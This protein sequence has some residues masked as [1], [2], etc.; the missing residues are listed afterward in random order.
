MTDSASTREILR[1]LVLLT[2][3][4]TRDNLIIEKGKLLDR[5][6]NFFLDYSVSMYFITINSYKTHLI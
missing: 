2:I 3:K 6:E 4:E 5:G 1:L